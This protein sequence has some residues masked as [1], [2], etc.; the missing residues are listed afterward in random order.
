MPVSG[1]MYVGAKKKERVA[2]PALIYCY[3]ACRRTADGVVL[4]FLL[5]PPF[6]VE[7]NANGIGRE[8]K[9]NE[10]DCGG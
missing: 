2:K 9:W 8:N 6:S 10:Q 4:N 7:R 5:V 1:L 3:A